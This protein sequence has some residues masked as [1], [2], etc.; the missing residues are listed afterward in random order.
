[1]FSLMLIINYEPNQPGNKE[2]KKSSKREGQAG[3]VYQ[4]EVLLQQ[5]QAAEQQGKR[6]AQNQEEG[7]PQ[8]EAESEP[9]AASSP[10][11]STQLRA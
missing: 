1:M 10:L 11:W 5:L 3:P 7:E 4:Q 8:Q 6:E 2:A 9:P